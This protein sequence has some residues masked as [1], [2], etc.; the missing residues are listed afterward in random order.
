MKNKLIL[1]TIVILL[2][3][4][5]INS[6]K[7]ISFFDSSEIF[8]H[9][10]SDLKTNSKGQ[11]NIKMK[12]QGI[13]FLMYID[14]NTTPIVS[15]YNGIYIVKDSIRMVSKEGLN[16]KILKNR[17]KTNYWNVEKKERTRF[18]KEI[19]KYIGGFKF[20]NGIILKSLK[21]E[22]YNSISIN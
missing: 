22:E 18:R 6:Q 9:I 14:E 13:R 16:V 7:K 17:S 1:V 5:T 10:L 19:K 21:K 20:E 3:G 11:L 15:S 4:I 2:K 12:N 8:T